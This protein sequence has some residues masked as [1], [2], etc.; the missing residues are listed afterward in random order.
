[1]M[2]HNL[3]P[4]TIGESL[5]LKDIYMEIKDL[6][7][8]DAKNL[9]QKIDEVVNML[10]DNATEIKHERD[11][12]ETGDDNALKA[13]AYDKLNKIA[14]KV[15]RY[16]LSTVDQDYEVK[17]ES[18]VAMKDLM[19][20]P[21]LDL[22]VWVVE[23]LLGVELDSRTKAEVIELKNLYDTVKDL[24]LVE[25]KTLKADLEQVCD[26]LKH[27]VLNLDGIGQS[28]NWNDD[29]NVKMNCAEHLQELLLKLADMKQGDKK[30]NLAVSSYVKK[31]ILDLAKQPCSDLEDITK[32]VF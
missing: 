2:H 12:R 20:Y 14:E 24:E 16:G 17:F 29:Y 3:T 8:V 13:L 25:A 11:E 9:K 15:P 21:D 23:D 31:V 18:K 27:D 32:Q 30:I 7:P 1:M 28:R 10:Q 4:M 6:L 22:N 26:N 5:M 19:H